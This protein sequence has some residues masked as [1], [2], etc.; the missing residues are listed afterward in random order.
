[1]FPLK[2]I[3]ET[4]ISVVNPETHIFVAMNLMVKDGLTG[5]AVVD[6]NEKLVG[7]LSEK[8]VL[9]MLISGAE[10][11]RQTV[12][13]YMVTDIKRFRLEDSAVDV[14]DFF[15]NNPIHIVPIVDEENT[16]VGLVRRRDIIFLILRIRG[17]IYRK[18]K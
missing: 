12:S 5:L 13:D 14:C 16:Y 4:D 3:M 17:K 2:S 15:M 9:S 18:K 1:M 8:E 10:A 6:V 11:D 7:F